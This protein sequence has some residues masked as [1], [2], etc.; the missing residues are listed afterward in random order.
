[1]VT[2]GAYTAGSTIAFNGVQVA[3]SGV[4]AAGDSFA[5]NQS[6]AEDVFTSLQKLVT[7]LNKPSGA[8]ATKAQLSTLLG[9]SLQQLDQVTDHMLGV[10]SQVGARL[11]TL[12]DATSSRDALSVELQSS[13]SDLRDLD[14]AEAL[15]KMNQQIVG[16]QAAQLSYSKISQLSLFNYLT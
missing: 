12:D 1:V 11:S 8:A 4:P 9:G 10:R 15:T 2:S 3:V 7:A 6:G 14:Y 5:I 16:L 13:I